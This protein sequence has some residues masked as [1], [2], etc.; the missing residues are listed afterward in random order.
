MLNLQ[1]LISAHHIP[2]IIIAFDHPLPTVP[3]AAEAAG[4]PPSAI[5]KTLILHDG[6]ARYVAVVLA[7]DQ[8]LDLNKVQRQVGAKRL[9]FLEPEEVLR[10][11]GYPAGGTPPFGFAQ[12][13]P[14]L[15]DESVMEKDFVLGGGGRPELLVKIAPAELVKAAGATVGDFAQRTEDGGRKTEA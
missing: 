6:H 4:V 2:A 15:V 13:I 10:V 3:L 7:G 1:S 8:R 9:K 11:T 14:T 5:I 12:P